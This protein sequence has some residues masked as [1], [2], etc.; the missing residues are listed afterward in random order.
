MTIIWCI[1][2][3]IWSVMDRIICHFGPFFP[4]L[5][6]WQ[7][8]KSKFW[9]SEKEVWRYY[10]FTHVYHKW[11]SKSKFWKSK[12]WKTEKV[13][14]NVIILHMFTINDNQIMHGSLDIECNRQIL[15]SFWTSFCPI[16]PL[17]IQNIKIS[18]KLKKRLEIFLLYTCIP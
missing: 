16:T 12:F 1:V 8:K 6:L 18:K 17:T 10:H 7:P 15:L 14:G 4:L 13:P 3:E 11:Q 5:P 2:P 9:K